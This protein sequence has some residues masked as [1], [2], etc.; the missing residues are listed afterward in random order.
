MYPGGMRAHLIFFLALPIA[1][2]AQGPA[3][4]ITRLSDGSGTIGLP[5]G[6]NVT[7][8][9]S[10]VSASGPEG[11]VDLGINVPAYTPQAAAMTPLRPPVVA[12]FGDPGADA[13]IIG[14]YF[15]H[16]PPQSIRIMERS[17]VTWWTTGPGE[18]LHFVAP[19]MGQEC[20][21]IVLTGDTGFGTFMYYSSGVCAKPQQFAAN[22][23]VL[24]RIWASWKVSDSVYQ[25]R[26]RD[27]ACSLE[28]VRRI[29]EHVNRR[30][31]RAFDRA[32]DAWDDL[33]RR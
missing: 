31:Q 5:P 8:I 15:R 26:L 4:R 11:T 17:P 1:C 18:T 27:A 3:L 32:N 9:N 10:M 19:S 22:L 7:A 14:G 24:L 30:Q 28:S 29:I 23:P 20:L 13:Q 16:I 21:A 12:P 33:M 2:L 6:W 25:A